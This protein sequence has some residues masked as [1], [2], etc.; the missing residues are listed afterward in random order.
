VKSGI[1]RVVHFVPAG[2]PA[3]VEPPLCRAAIVTEVADGE[4]AGLFVLHRVES[5]FQDGVKFDAYRGPR[6]WHWPERSD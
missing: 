4:V 5:P 6:T 3:A 1:G 2:T